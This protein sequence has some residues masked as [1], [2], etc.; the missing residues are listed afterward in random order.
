[1]GGQQNGEIQFR[2]LFRDRQ[3]QVELSA[4]LNH[5]LQDLIDRILIFAAPGSDFAMHLFSKRFRKVAPLIL[6]A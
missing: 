3:S 2:L 4:A 1:M 6:P 5:H